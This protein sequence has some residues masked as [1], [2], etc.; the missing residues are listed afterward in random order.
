VQI[1]HFAIHG[2][3]DQSGFSDGLILTDNLA[4]RPVVIEGIPLTAS[5][6]VFLNACQVG[7]GN[8][9]LG[10]YAGTAAAF[11]RAGASAVIA[12]LWSI[13]DETAS[14]IALAFYQ[15]ALGPDPRSPA[16]FLTNQRAKF[17]ESPTVS[18]YM[19]Y[20]FFGHP[21]YLLHEEV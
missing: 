3:Y 13:D 17:A 18:T 21:A 7:S 5:P 1:L 4:L 6:L 15:E 14:R 8:E 16:E 19:A 9:T 11:L 2:K 20:Q 12:P 10:D